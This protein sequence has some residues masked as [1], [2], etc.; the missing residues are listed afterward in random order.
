ME[1]G[2]LEISPVHQP[3]GRLSTEAAMGYL[4]Q[5]IGGAEPVFEWLHATATARISR[6]KSS[7]YGCRTRR[8][9]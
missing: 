2:P 8:A 3:D 5:A 7:W 1:R 6:A 4:Q 9:R